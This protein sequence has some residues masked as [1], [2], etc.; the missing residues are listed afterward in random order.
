MTSKNLTPSTF[1]VDILVAGDGLNYPKSGQ[2]CTVQ[3]TAYIMNENGTE[4]PVFDSTHERG[5][6]FRFKLG[7]EQVIDG[8]DRG[9]ARLSLAERAKITIGSNLAYGVR[10]FPFLVPPN[11]ALMYDLELL[12]F[13]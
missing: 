13:K 4:G 9:V 3:Y 11:T 1:K 5:K 10:G 7:T 8:L 6:P 2:V 12:E